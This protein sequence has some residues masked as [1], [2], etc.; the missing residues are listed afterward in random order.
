[1]HESTLLA[2][3]VHIVAHADDDNLRMRLQTWDIFGARRSVWQ[4]KE[5]ERRFHSA[6]ERDGIVWEYREHVVAL[7]P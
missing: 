1:M 2:K 7:L 3:A 5:L 6:Q 4:H